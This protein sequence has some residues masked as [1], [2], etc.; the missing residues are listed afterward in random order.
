MLEV[1]MSVVVLPR[2]QEP[3]SSVSCVFSLG[4][5]F[6]WLSSTYMCQQ[7]CSC[8][9]LLRHCIRCAFALARES[10]GRSRL[11]RIAMI[12]MTTNSSIKVKAAGEDEHT[13]RCMEL[14]LRL[15]FRRLIYPIIY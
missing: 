4:G 12:A 11:A 3:A 5:V 7:S 2:I 13:L 9:R 14:V 6:S 10:A 8:F 15:G 1:S